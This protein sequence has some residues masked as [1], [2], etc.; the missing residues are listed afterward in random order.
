MIV[1]LLTNAICA[2]ASAVIDGRSFGP[3]FWLTLAAT[4][5][6]FMASERARRRSEDEANDAF[7][8]GFREGR[9]SVPRATTKGGGT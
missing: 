4:T 2:A 9:E 5:A 6:M 8:A 3:C 7:L 1:Y